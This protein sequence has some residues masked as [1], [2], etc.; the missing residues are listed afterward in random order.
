MIKINIQKILR[1]LSDTRPQVWL[2][3][4]FL[5]VYVLYFIIPIF[6]SFR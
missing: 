4:G 1:L 2:F 3:A 5:I 6:F